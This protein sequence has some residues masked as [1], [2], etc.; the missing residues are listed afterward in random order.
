MSFDARLFSDPTFQS[1]AKK[2]CTSKVVAVLLQV[3]RRAADGPRLLNHPLTESLI[4]LTMIRSE[5]NVAQGALKDMEVDLE[6][7]AKRLER[8]LEHCD[9]VVFVSQEQVAD[10]LAPSHKEV[11]ATIWDLIE[12][13]RQE[14]ASLKH[15][16]VGTE[17]LL[18]A[19][20]RTADASLSSILADFGVTYER[21]QNAIVNIL[22]S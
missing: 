14:A 21:A 11:S 13:G 16:Y 1:L 2:R 6:R 22:Y 17:H 5:I 12:R 15:D 4:L 10:D 9:R 8:L 20:I 18:L 19:I 3:L 7:L